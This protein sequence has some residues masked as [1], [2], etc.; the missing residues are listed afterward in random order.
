MA[1]KVIFAGV[2]CKVSGTLPNAGL[3]IG[4]DIEERDSRG[5]HVNGHVMV[6]N[7]LVAS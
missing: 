7:G 3:I 6:G 4:S 5:K 2:L 1:S